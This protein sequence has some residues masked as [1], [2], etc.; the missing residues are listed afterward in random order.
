[1]SSVGP[2]ASLHEI[3]DRARQCDTAEVTVIAVS[4]R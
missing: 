1:M 4:D 3:C 2:A